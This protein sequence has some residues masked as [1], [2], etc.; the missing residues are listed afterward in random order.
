MHIQP[1]SGAKLG[2]GEE[3]SPASY[4]K[5]KK[6]PNFGKKGPNWMKFSNFLFKI[7]L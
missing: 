3:A 2:A 4:W 7:L 5:S 6:V 1:H